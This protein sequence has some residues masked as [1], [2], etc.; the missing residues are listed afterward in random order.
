MANIND[1]GFPFPSVEGDRQYGSAEWR[2]FF[3]GL[4]ISGVLGD[5]GN[6]LA[7]TQ[8]AVANKTVKIGTG[9]VLV[10]GAIRQIGVAT[11]LTIADNTSGNPRIDRIV[12]R[13]NTTDRK[14]EFAV[15]QGTP[16]A[17]PSAPTLTQTSATYEI[18]LAKIVVA[19]GFST[20]INSNITDERTYMTY[21]DRVLNDRMTILENDVESAVL[22][23]N[24]FNAT[25]ALAKWYGKYSQMSGGAGLSGSAQSGLITFSAEDN[26]NFSAINLATSATKIIIPSGVTKV[27][28]YWKGSMSTPSTADNVTATVSLRKNGVNVQTMASLT[29]DDGAAAM[30]GYFQSA[31]VNCVE[32]DYFELHAALATYS[33][34]WNSAISAGSIFGMEVIG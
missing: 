15:L 13:L 17:S 3:E 30:S 7:V 28:F 4:A 1:Y 14:I 18:S 34:S 12:A 2:T 11:S 23:M 6:E 24:T 26:D 5:I 9:A 21:R 10:K 27:K 19:N 16:A 32:G 33:G 22:D 8:Q 31:Y 25:L 20:I 29:S